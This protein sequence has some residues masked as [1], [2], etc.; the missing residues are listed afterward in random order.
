M[1][2][3]ISIINSKSIFGKY[4]RTRLSANILITKAEST[5]K[6]IHTKALKIFFAVFPPAYSHISIISRFGN[7]SK[8][9]EAM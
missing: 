4:I 7:K 6:Y 8:I 5:S 1:A 2:I 9:F 3:K